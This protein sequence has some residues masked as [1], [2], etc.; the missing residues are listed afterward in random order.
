MLENNEGK[1][2]KLRLNG[3]FAE[4]DETRKSYLILK[5]S[6][7]SADSFL[8]ALEIVREERGAQRGALTDEEQDLLR[9]MV[10]IGAAGLDSL[11]KQ[12]IRDCLPRLV[13]L[14]ENVQQGLEIFVTRQLRGEVEDLN[15]SV[16]NKFLAKVLLADSHQ[17]QV[18]EEYVQHLTGNSLQSAS[19]VMK[20]VNALGIDPKQISI[21]PNKLKPIFDIRNRII[22]ELDINFE[23]ARRNR[24]SRRLSDMVDRTNLLLQ[25]S[26]KILEAVYNKLSESELQVAGER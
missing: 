16:S 14:D 21:D 23:A 7:E 6:H 15:T 19:E 17:T 10:V 26:E 1:L 25:L 22:H 18:I 2:R 5:Y 3:T 20:A 4:L 11:L 24:S 9:M 8:E 12:I 13:E